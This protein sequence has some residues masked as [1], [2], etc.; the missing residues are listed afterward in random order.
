MNQSTLEAFMAWGDRSNRDTAHMLDLAVAGTIDAICGGGTV[1]LRPVRLEEIASRIA[2]R[3]HHPDGA[4][5]VTL[6]PRE[7]MTPEEVA[8]IPQ[9]EHGSDVN[10][11][12]T[13]AE[14]ASLAGRILN[15]SA[16]E[17]NAMPIFDLFDMAKRLAGSALTQRG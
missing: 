6:R 9:F 7:D 1:V 12:R 8:A 5:I 11:E 3:E 17:V 14:I 2:K 16:A 4:W 10:T 15:M 13:S